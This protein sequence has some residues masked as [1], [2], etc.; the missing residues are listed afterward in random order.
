MTPGE[1]ESIRDVFKGS[2]ATLLLFLAY[3]VFPLIGTPAGIVAPFPALFYSLKQGRTIG[4]AIVLVTVAVLALTEPT[5]ALLYL[6]QAGLLSLLLAEFL[7][8]GYGGAR[9]IA[10]AVAGVAILIVVTAAVYGLGSGVDL[11]G[12]VRA[13]IATSI[14]QTAALY[15]KGGFST[16]ELAAIQEALKQSGVLIGTIYPALL[17]LLMTAF[18][19]LNLALL[20][21]NAGRL[22]QPPELGRFSTYRSPDHLIW[23]VIA[24]GFCLLLDHPVV[25]Q[26]S[27]NILIVTLGLY[28]IQGL[29]IIVTFFDRFA[30]SS[31]MRGI[32]Y[33]LLAVQPYLAIG[34][35]LFGLFDL[36]LN[37]RTPKTGENL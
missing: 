19:G 9:S 21:K 20:R 34:V 35:T 15:Q 6:F 31:L 8:Q 18:A 22:L 2:A 27:L 25:F 13:G 33:V 5:I 17:V 10:G 12:V 4:L 14:A 36:W 16:E 37:F 7:R 32:F 29:A 28:F 11:N 1:R 26:A 23:L 30:V 3:A 24:S